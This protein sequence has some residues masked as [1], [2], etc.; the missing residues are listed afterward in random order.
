VVSLLCGRNVAFSAISG[1]HLVL[2]NGSCV[3]LA[4]INPM[5]ALSYLETLAIPK[6]HAK[7]SPVMWG[8]SSGVLLTLF[9]AATSQD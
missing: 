9:Y 3:V 6:S 4:A 2:G 5:S 8:L 1:T 7:K